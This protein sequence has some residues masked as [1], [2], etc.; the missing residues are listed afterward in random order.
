ML[1]FKLVAVI[2]A[3]VNGVPSEQPSKVLPYK[4]DF[5]S[6][7]ACMEFARADESAALRNE[8]KEF[9]QSQRGA[10]VAKIGCMQSGEDN[11]I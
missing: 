2:F 1:K 7:E 4:E 10:I 8:V 3:V 5:K 11:S 9:V 6:L